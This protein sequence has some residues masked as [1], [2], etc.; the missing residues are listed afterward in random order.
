MG[1]EKSRVFLEMGMGFQKCTRLV[2]FGELFFSPQIC[3]LLVMTPGEKSI[4]TVSL[5]S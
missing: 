4:Y 5:F 3:L 2:Q 1:S